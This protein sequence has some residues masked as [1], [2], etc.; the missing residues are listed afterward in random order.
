MMEAKKISLI[1]DKGNLKKDSNRRAQS[2]TAQWNAS[3]FKL[4]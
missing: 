3:P 4:I 2:K 1:V